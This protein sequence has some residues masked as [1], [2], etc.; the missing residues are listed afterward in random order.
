VYSSEGR[1]PLT[2]TVSDT[3]AGLFSYIE[4]EGA[5]RVNLWHALQCVLNKIHNDRKLSKQT[6]ED[7]LST[8]VNDNIERMRDIKDSLCS[9]VSPPKST[10]L[11]ITKAHRNPPLPA[12]V[13]SG[14]TGEVLYQIESLKVDIRYQYKHLLLEYNAAL[15]KHATEK[16]EKLD[17]ADRS[18]R[19]RAEEAQSRKLEEKSER[20]R[21]EQRTDAKREQ[22]IR[23]EDAREERKLRAAELQLKVHR[24]NVVIF[25]TVLIAVVYMLHARGSV[26]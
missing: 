16:A 22:E 8:A 4:G 6:K 10:A 1:S 11:T 24:L 20:L 7:I 17:A 19:S 21:R 9:A 25:I 3:N 12:G 2:A 26:M 18:R 5:N 14:E 15:S 23:R 13:Y